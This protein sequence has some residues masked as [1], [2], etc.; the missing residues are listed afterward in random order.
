[1][2]A[3]REQLPGERAEL[4]FLSLSLSLLA[5]KEKKLVIG[6]N[7]IEILMAQRENEETNKKM[8]MKSECRNQCAAS[9]K[10]KPATKQHNTHGTYSR[11]CLQ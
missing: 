5:K 11:K 7:R 3:K 6:D 8:K 2:E 4:V 10:K 1:M 9:H